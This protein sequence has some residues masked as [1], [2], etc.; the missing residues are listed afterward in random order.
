MTLR[1]QLKR[2]SWKVD[3]NLREEYLFSDK[4]QLLINQNIVFKHYPMLSNYMVK[5]IFNT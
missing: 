2:G 5:D 3:K 4:D 1:I